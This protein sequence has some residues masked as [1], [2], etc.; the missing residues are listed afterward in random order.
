MRFLGF[1]LGAMV[2]GVYSVDV[3]EIVVQVRVCRWQVFVPAK[4]IANVGMG[5]VAES[6]GV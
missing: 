4:S 1:T 2:V 5:G 6:G 3:S